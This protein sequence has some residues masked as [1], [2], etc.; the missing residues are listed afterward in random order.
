VVRVHFD[1]D[2]PVGARRQRGDLPDHLQKRLARRLH[3]AGV[4]RHAVEAPHGESVLDLF[5][6][7]AVQKE[8]HAVVLLYYSIPP[9][10]F[11]TIS[12]I[13]VISSMA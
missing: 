11:N 10:R 7:R 4:G 9:F 12:F 3:V 5:D 2:R 8:F 1:G 6:Y 13:S